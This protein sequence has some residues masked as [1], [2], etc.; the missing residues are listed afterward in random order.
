[1][2]G[3]GVN[4]VPGGDPQQGPDQGGMGQAG[5]ITPQQQA[6]KFLSL[7]LPKFSGPGGLAPP[8]LLN[9]PGGG[10]LPA[11]AAGP[12]PGIPG[13]QPGGFDPMSGASNPMLEALL[14]LARMKPGGTGGAPPM[15]PAPTPNF[16][17]G[18]GGPGTGLPREIFDPANPEVVPVPPGSPTIDYPPGGG[19]GPLMNPPDVGGPGPGVL[20]RPESGMWGPY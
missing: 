2:A 4:F 5:G 8:S 6:V 17:P 7:R 15:G 20:R 13:M 16:V 1:M 12:M 9:G 19:A 3:F 18:G 10:G 11:G 14:R